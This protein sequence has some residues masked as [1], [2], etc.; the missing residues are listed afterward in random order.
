MSL[1]SVKT[2]TLIPHQLPEYIRDDPDNYSKFVD[3][4]QAYYEWMERSGNVLDFTNNIPN[5]MDIDYTTN[6][7]LDYFANDFLQYFPEDILTSKSQTIKLAREL[8]H[9]KGTPASYKLL[10][11]ILYNSDFEYLYTKDFLLKPSTSTWF[12]IKSL[13]LSTD[14]RN[15]LDA[16]NCR[17]FG[18][19]SKSIAIIENVLISENKIELVISNIERLFQSGETITVVDNNNQPILFNGNELSAVI[20]GQISQVTIDPNNRGLIYNPGDPVIVY[21]GLNPNSLSPVGAVAKVGT[22]TNGSIYNISVLNGGFGYR[23]YPYSSINIPDSGGANAI[24]SAIDVTS[25]N[26]EQITI[27]SDSLYAKRNIVIGQADY[28]FSNIAV[29]N[30]NTTLLNALSFQTISTYPIYSV[31]LLNGG[32]NISTLPEVTCQSLYTTDYVDEDLSSLGILS[33]IQII[34][35]GQGYTNTDIVLFSGGSGFGA[36]ANVINVSSSGAII[37]VS[38]ISKNGYFAGGM[39]YTNARLPSLNVV[40]SNAQAYGAVLS[41]AGILGTGASFS[42][43]VTDVGSINTID[44]TEY[45]EDYVS[46]PL[47]SL[48]VEDIIVSNTNISNLPKNGDIVY[49]GAS[50]EQSTYSANVYSTTLLQSNIVPENSLFQ[51][52]VYDYNL[53]PNPSLPLKFVTNESIVN[54]DTTGYASN[55]FYSGSPAFDTNG[56]KIYG[57]GKAKATASFLNGLVIS[58]GQYLDTTGHPSSYSVLQS[59]VYNNYTYRIT[60]EKEIEKYRKTLLDLLHPAGTKVVGRYSLKSNASYLDLMSDALYTGKKLSAYT[61]DNASN[62][63]IITDFKNLSNNIVVFENLAGANI[64]QFI[65]S[66]QSGVS[67]SVLAISPAHGPEIKSEVIK[68]N[69]ASNTVVLKSNAWL[70]YP[71][72]AYASTNTGTSIINIKKVTKSYDIINN[73]QYSNTSYP[74]KDVIFATDTVSINNV[75]YTVQSI[76]YVAGTITVSNTIN[77]NVANSLISVKR[78]YNTTNVKIFGSVGFVYIPEIVTEQGYTLS[79][80]D[81]KTIILE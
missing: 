61:G 9:L 38:Y 1:N 34:N 16:V 7:F 53:S 58:Q 81:G 65:F 12:S 23:V 35:G 40:S 71:S 22:V 47:V 15:F 28:E 54:I 59:E 73:G 41:V 14:D 50:L 26:A 62:I 68:V 79:T 25:A 69:W 11:R 18:S 51:L 29:S 4:I 74:I 57:N 49:Q 67:N 64:G 5:Y 75:S 80:Q 60:V 63:R 10:F 3:F 33:P 46:K 2:S 39:G 76:N 55:T 20:V 21:G 45:G 6:Q 56:L 19:T 17:I 48:A 52:R 36:Y 72:V 30:A 37:S 77:Q 43:S 24:V 70:T 66:G 42:A 31:L 8:Y 78:N 32:G 27:P 44:I 13:R